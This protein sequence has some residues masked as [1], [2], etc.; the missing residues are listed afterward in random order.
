MD[1]LEGST[2]RAWMAAD[3]ELRQG[4]EAMRSAGDIAAARQAFASLSTALTEV[5]RGFG[6]STGE[7]HVFYCP[8]AFD[9]EGAAWL[10]QRERTQNP[11]F[12]SMYGCGSRQETFNAAG[13]E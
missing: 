2:H 11:Y 13:A 4:A 9:N 1:A 5:A 10:Q 3:R 6:V 8:M 12:G 7:V